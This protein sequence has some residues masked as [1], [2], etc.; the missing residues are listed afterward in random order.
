VAGSPH[1]PP[2]QHDP[3]AVLTRCIACDAV[4]SSVRSIA[5][6]VTAA[7]AGTAA[8]AAGANRVIE[9]RQPFGGGRSHE[10]GAA[11]LRPRALFVIPVLGI[12]VLVALWI[13]IFARLAVEK[14]AALHEAGA[15]AAILSTSLSQHTVKAIHQVDQITRFIKYEYEKAPDSFDLATTVDNAVVQGDSLMQVSLLDAN[16]RLVASTAD[17]EPQPVDL[18]S[19]DYFRVHER[20]N[21]DRLY[22]GQP[23][24]GRLPGHAMLEFTR[25]LNRPVGSFAGV[26]AVSEDPGYFT[27]DFYNNAAIG[28]DGVI[29]VVADN[30]TVLARRTGGGASSLAGNANAAGAA[31][32]TWPVSAQASGIYADPIDHVTRIMSYRHVDGYPL[33]VL[34]GLSMDEELAD[35]Q[36]T[37]DVYLLMATFVSLAILSFFAVATGLISRTPGREAAQLVQYDPL[38]S[39][40]NRYSTLQ[41]LRHEVAQP[42]S[43][44]RLAI[45]LIDLDNFKTVNDTLG[46]NAGDVVLQMGAAR[47]ADAIGHAGALSRIGGDEFAVIAKGDDIEARAVAL[48]ESVSTAFTH[49]FDVRGSTFVLHASTGIALHTVEHESEIDLLKKADL[50]MYAAKEAGRNGFRFYSPKL[51]HRADHQMKWEQQLRVALGEGQ[52]FLAY[53]PKIDLRRRCITGFEALARWNH[54]QYGLVAA[55][56]FIPVAESTGLIVPIGDFVI[57]TACAQLA[58]WQR[59]GLDTLTLAVNIS[60]VQFWRGDLVETVAHAIES[61]GVDARRLEL[62]ITETAMMEYPDLVSEKLHA[63]RRL[64]VRV[65]LDDFGT[66]YSSLSHLSRFKVDTL[67][68]DRSFVQAIPADRSVCVMV[69]AI[70]NL[71]RSLGLTVVIEGTETDEQVTWLSA[72][73]PIEAQGFLFS[74]PVP[75][76]DVPALI[77]RYGIC[78]VDMAASRRE[79]QP[80]RADDAPA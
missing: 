43:V 24:K 31:G 73:G 41:R 59:E 57:H 12:A 30:G 28:R 18:S 47:L 78:G 3:H 10:G 79:L 20:A 35:Y 15:S 51:G 67:K 66:G 4:H 76:A 14:D 33:G 27:N 16:G 72:L 74:R 50:A 5:V 53:Q 11:R 2:Y 46:H 36:H 13:A 6:T 29:A 75:V 22:V 9:H 34:V 68:V 65:A 62:E 52:I 64:G 61:A 25:R 60:A 63:L 80:E 37:R 39:L 48:A 44:G 54:P 26:V 70:V 17:P 1:R 71:A 42:G 58:Q 19:R 56:E 69:S 45:L 21:T 40:P 32:G 7:A 55:S 23:E 38:T 77:R 8:R 49:P